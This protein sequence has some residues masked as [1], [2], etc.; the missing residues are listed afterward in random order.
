M[1]PEQAL[2]RS[3]TTRLEIEVAFESAVDE[4]TGHHHA[5]GRHFLC[6]DRL[7]WFVFGGCETV[8][9]GEDAAVAHI[10][11]LAA[12]VALEVLPRLRVVLVTEL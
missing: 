8:E 11:L 9:T 5:C 12:A 4:D 6:R 1:N 2:A 10:V 3:F 7:V